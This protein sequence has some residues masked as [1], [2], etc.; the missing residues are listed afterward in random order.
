MLV[1]PQWL[2]ILLTSPRIKTDYD[3]I[4]GLLSSLH[5]KNKISKTFI[6]CLDNKDHS[7]DSNK[8]ITKYFKSS[9]IKDKKLT[10][11]NVDALLFFHYQEFFTYLGKTKSW[12]KFEEF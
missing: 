8:F 12:F 6:E 7:D 1:W 2:Q 3:E 5:I 4:K 10:D 11:L 9:W